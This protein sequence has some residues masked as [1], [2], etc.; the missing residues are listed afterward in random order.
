MKRAGTAAA[1]ATLVIA[2]AAHAGTSFQSTWK[3]PD[4]QP[5]TFQGKK[6]VAVFMSQEEGMRRGVEGILAAELTK[7]GMQGVAAYSLIPTAE[8]RDE[9]KAKARIEGSGAAGAV[10]LRIVGRDQQISG[11][12]ASYWAGPS[13]GAMWGGYWGYGWG[14]IYDPGYLKSETVLLV[15]T[16][17]YSL[18][19]NKLVWA[20]QTKTTNPKNANSVVQTLVGKVANEI[21]KA[22]LVQ[23]GK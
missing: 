21:K 20:G 14:G 9:A 5:G 1:V 17:V 22:G 3:A 11:S 23:K 16:L 18:E 15:E 12:S 10:V 2:A 8:I 4:A 19:Q 13:Y 6:V 7:R